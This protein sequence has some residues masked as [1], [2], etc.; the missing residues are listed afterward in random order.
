MQL[1]LELEASK[2]WRGHIQKKKELEGQGNK[3]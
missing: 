3:F 2:G 1:K